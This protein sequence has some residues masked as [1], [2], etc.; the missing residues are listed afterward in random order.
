VAYDGPERRFAHRHHVT[1][2]AVQYRR[3]KY[4]GFSKTEMSRPCE[5]GDISGRGVKFYTADKL[6]TGT[7]LEVLF[8]C[9]MDVEA[10]DSIPALPGKVMWQEWSTKRK[11][12]RTGVRFDHM[13]DEMRDTI[14]KMVDAAAKHDRRYGNGEQDIL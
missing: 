13:R 1:C 6:R 7:P 11:C 14:M 5:L 8:D 4:L 12:F 3:P 9:P 10:A 2:I